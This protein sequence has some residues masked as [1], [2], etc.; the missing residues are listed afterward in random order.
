MS[1]KS[2]LGTSLRVVKYKLHID[3]GDA[4]ILLLMKG[5]LTIRKVKSSRLYFI[6]CRF[7]GKKLTFECPSYPFLQAHLDR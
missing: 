7:Q 4:E 3:A 5:K 2:L 1:R 6:C